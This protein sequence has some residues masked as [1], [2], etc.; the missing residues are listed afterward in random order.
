LTVAK[1]RRV[2]RDGIRFQGFRYLD[3]TLAAYV[4]EWVTIRYD[5]GDLAEL[6]VYHRDR[7]LCRAICPELA[8]AASGLKD[9]ERAR[10]ARRRD[11]RAGIAERADLVERLLAVHAEPV[12]A[13]EP[14]GPAPAAPRLK[15]YVND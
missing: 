4:G 14:A 7:F 5:P 10:N 15:R 1:A 2:Q 11:L 3:L 13:A 6:R 12:A 8:G 9:L